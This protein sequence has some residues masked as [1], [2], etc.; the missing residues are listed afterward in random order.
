[1]DDYTR[2]LLK[3]AEEIDR[4]GRDDRRVRGTSFANERQAGIIRDGNSRLGEAK[5][6]E[7]NWEQGDLPALL[8]RSPAQRAESLA[9]R[10]WQSVKDHRPAET[11]LV[12]QLLHEEQWKKGM[13]ISYEDVK[14]A[15][16]ELMRQAA[17][18]AGGP[19]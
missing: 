8:R 3:K 19:Y 1:M 4:S 5:A 14:Q 2:R 18:K 9:N 6:V 10:L 12:L 15:A 13:P 11:E 7:F 17:A 16:M